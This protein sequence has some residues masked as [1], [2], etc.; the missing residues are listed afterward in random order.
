MSSPEEKEVMVKDCFKVQRNAAE[1]AALASRAENCPEQRTSPPENPMTHDQEEAFE[2]LLEL[3]KVLEMVG[4]LE[5]LLVG[6][7]D[8]L[9]GSGYD[10]PFPILCNRP[11]DCSIS[12]TNALW[13]KLKKVEVDLREVLEGD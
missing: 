6:F 9:E 10:N 7:A 13:L 4:G 11:G 12:E 2:L 1:K 3:R 8:E 5:E